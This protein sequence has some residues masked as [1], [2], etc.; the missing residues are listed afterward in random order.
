MAS[1]LWVLNLVPDTSC[2]ATSWRSWFDE[3]KKTTLF[4]RSRV[5]ILR[6]ENHL[7]QL[8]L[9]IPPLIIM[10]KIC[11]KGESGGPE[12]PLGMSLIYCWQCKPSSSLSRERKRF[13]ATEAKHKQQ[14][15]I[16]HSLPHAM[17]RTCW[18]VTEGAH[19]FY[20]PVC[21]SGAEVTPFSGQAL[22][23]HQQVE[24]SSRQCYS[25]DGLVLETIW[26]RTHE[27]N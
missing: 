26:L 8:G 12:H 6:P 19:S 24:F 5:K 2:S 15:V 22:Q 1:E 14:A 9:E 27:K 18:H 4:V 23:S 17:L 16:A 10:K 25:N 21:D 11:D 3:A 13:K 20:L 7:L